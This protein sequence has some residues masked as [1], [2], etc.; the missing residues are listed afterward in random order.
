MLDFSLSLL[1]Q[2]VRPRLQIRFFMP[3]LL[4]GADLP[5]GAEAVEDWHRDVHEHDIVAL[6]AAPF[7]ALDGFETI[8]R[9]VDYL[10]I[11][12]LQICAQQ[13]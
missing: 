1:S 10:I 11:S 3:A 7:E 12:S 8:A 5:R 9:F 4:D 2:L 6:R 13:S